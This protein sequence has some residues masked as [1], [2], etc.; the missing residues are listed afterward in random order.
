MRQLTSVALAM[1]LL[2]MVFPYAAFA[3]GLEPEFK[4][5]G[6]DARRVTGLLTAQ[7]SAVAASKRGWPGGSSTLV[8]VDESDVAYAA[9]AS[10]L[11]AALDAP[12]LLAGKSLGWSTEREI[13]RLG[14]EKVVL[15]GS[16]MTLG[17]V[18]ASDLAQRGLSVESLLGSDPIDTSDLVAR[19]VHE[20]SDAY[21]IVIGTSADDQQL[22][23]AAVEA[24]RTRS[25]L[26]VLDGT[27]LSPEQLGTIRS[28]GARSAVIIGSSRYFSPAVRTAL[29]C[30][31]LAVAVMGGSVDDIT[32]RSFEAATDGDYSVGTTM[33]L[34]TRVEQGLAAPA[35]SARLGAPVLM[36][37]APSGSESARQSLLRNCSMIEDLLV[38]GDW[39]SVSSS[40]MSTLTYSASTVYRASTVIVREQTIDGNVVAVTGTAITT[41]S[42]LRDMTADKLT[43]KVAAGDYVVVMPSAQ[44]P[45]GAYGKVTGIACRPFDPGYIYWI[46]PVAIGEIIQQGGVTARQSAALKQDQT[47]DLNWDGGFK[48]EIGVTLGLVASVQSDAGFSGKCKAG[49]TG[50]A[51]LSSELEFHLAIEGGNVSAFEYSF[52]NTATAKVS[53]TLEGE[54]KVKSTSKAFKKTM[55]GRPIFVTLPLCPIPIV[56]MPTIEYSA[57]MSGSFAGSLTASYEWKFEKTQGLRFENGVLSEQID[58]GKKPT[59]KPSASSHAKVQADLKLVFGEVKC[60]IKVWG[61]AGP[62]LTVTAFGKVSGSIDRNFSTGV[63]TGGGSVVVG[64]EV[65]AGV[66]FTV[67][68]L[69]ELELLDIR[70]FSFEITLLTLGKTTAGGAAKRSG[71]LPLLAHANGA[72]THPSI[73]ADG[74]YICFRSVA[75]NLLPG[76]PANQAYVLELST[77][78]L[79]CVSL[80]SRGRALGSASYSP[81]VISGNGRYVAFLSDDAGRPGTMVRDRLKRTTT[82]VDVSTSGIQSTQPSLDRAVA[83]SADG[84][85]VLFRSYASNL[86]PGAGTDQ[87]YA[88]DLVRK[89]TRCVSVDA[90]GRPIGILRGRDPETLAFGD[91]GVD[92][93]ADGRFAVFCAPYDQAGGTSQIWLH[94]L[95]TRR[96]RVVS[97]T[98][99][100]S[101]T[102]DRNLAPT[103]SADGRYVAYLG[104]NL[105]L[106][107]SSSPYPGIA[108][109]NVSTRT[110]GYASRSNSNKPLKGLGDEC[111]V[112]TDGSGDR[113]AFTLRTSEGQRLYVRDSSASKTYFISADLPRAWAYRVTECALSDDGT[114]VVFLANNGRSTRIYLF[115]S[116]DSW[117][118]DGAL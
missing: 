11:A 19:R 105:W 4:V 100:G 84:S 5:A 32:A 10:P 71:L 36:S 51:K 116:S 78:R 77:G 97:V 111:Y 26:L 108:R 8:L 117:I 74:K 113:V 22:L 68:K 98:K 48:Q 9:A 58:G 29:E 90:A 64:V 85:V 75:S 28:L 43:R 37:T 35:L 80:D 46:A 49:L 79:E 55:R 73:S 33:L 45:E 17:G 65:S 1:L 94:D 54:F 103:L 81:V 76:V 66:E 38:M 82:V 20:I 6:P 61:I 15:V 101:P 112:D 114:R 13:E 47:G 91:V 23:L 109:Q 63:L 52:S 72:L 107:A 44:R 89:T 92:L 118:G 30:E 86:V 41:K 50:E 12:V 56:L 18:V 14:V 60:A 27:E 96:S 88:R 104:D 69:V 67:L 95:E 115:L 3:G 110:M 57:Y 99:G 16:R 39:R 31:G 62:K 87:L 53:L 106:G 34:G 93:S 25:P 83:I 7:S 70:L 21:R 59:A 40:A 102:S 24:A 42:E 2:N